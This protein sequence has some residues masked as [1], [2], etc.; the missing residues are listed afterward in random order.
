MWNKNSMII[1]PVVIALVMPSSCFAIIP[2]TDVGAIMN[3]VKNY[4]QLK[5]QYDLLQHTYQSAQQ[6]LDQTKQ[7]TNDSE[8]HYGF[9]GLLNGTSDLKNREWSPDNWKSTL[10]GISGGN[11][12]R[13]QELVHTYKQNHPNLSQSDYMKGSSN[14][15]AKVYAQDVQVNR[16]VMTNATYSF[17]NIKTHLDTIHSLSAKIDQAKNTKSATDLNSRLL[18]EVAYIQTQE[19]KMQ[20]LMNQQM[21][22]SSADNIASKTASAKFNTLPN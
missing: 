2:V 15:K 19:L 18:A 12:A 11:S 10:Q 16:A 13:Y 22:Q 14:D 7:L 1:L 20:I 4:S 8:G 9:G 21:A 5:R 3:L 17:N 6:Q